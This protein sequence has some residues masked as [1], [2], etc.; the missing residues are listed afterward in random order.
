M[1]ATLPPSPRLPGQTRQALQRVVQNAMLT[2]D[3]DLT[4]SANSPSIFIR[5]VGPTVRRFYDQAGTLESLGI[6]Q[7]IAQTETSSI[8][9]DVLASSQSNPTG[10]TTGTLRSVPFGNV[11]DMAYRARQDAILAGFKVT[12]VSRP[13]AEKIFEEELQ[14][15]LVHR[16]EASIGMH[17]VSGGISNPGTALHPGLSV[18]VNTKGASLQILYSPAFFLTIKTVFGNSL[19]TPVYGSISPGLYVFGTQGPSV[20]LTFEPQ[21]YQFLLRPSSTW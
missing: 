4:I 12:D 6:R 21:Q 20:P 14:D 9:L 2:G 15:F 5:D 10:R 17:G 1:S 18:V 11:S 13:T 8:V 19:S 3:L 7:P 16:T